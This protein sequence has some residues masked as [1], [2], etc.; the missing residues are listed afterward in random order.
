MNRTIK[1]NKYKT[2][3]MALFDIQIGGDQSI[4]RI[5][6]D[7]ELSFVT[8]LDSGWNGDSYI[9]KNNKDRPLI[10]KL[11]RMD[12]Y[13]KNNKFESEYHRQVDFDEHVA[14]K[15]PDKF[16]VLENHGIIENCVFSHSKTNDVI[17]KADDKRKA[18]FIRKNAQPNCYYL[19]YKP[20]LDGTFKSIKDQIKNDEI[21]LSDFLIQMIKSMNVYRKLGFI[22]TDVNISNIMFKRFGKKYQ[23]YW[24]DYGNITNN[25]YPD[26]QLDIERKESVPFYKTDM[27]SDLLSLI[28]RFCIT[29]NIIDHKTSGIQKKEFI[30]GIYNNEKEKYDKVIEYLP[31]FDN[32]EQ[33]KINNNI[34][35]L[36]FRILYPKEY[37]KYYSIEYDNKEQ[38]V[39]DKILQCI[40]HSNDKTYDDL[41]DNLGG[42][43][44]FSKNEEKLLNDNMEKMSKKIV[45]ISD[46]IQL[47]N[48][49]NNKSQKTYTTKDFTTSDGVLNILNL[50]SKKDLILINHGEHL[51]IL[52]IKRPNTNQKDIESFIDDKKLELHYSIIDNRK[53]I[54]NTHDEVYCMHSIGKVFTGFL[55]MMLLDENIITSNDVKIP[56]QLDNDVE[57]KLPKTI[58]D[59]L[60]ETTM[61]D[62]MTHISGL[63]NYLGNYKDT[64]RKN[65]DENPIEPEDFIK[66]IHPDVKEK[67]KYNY[68]NTGLLLCGLSIKHL[69]NKRMK[70]NKTYNEILNEYIIIPAKLQTF[71]I[72]RPNNGIFNK[73]GVDMAEFFHGSPA[74]GYWIS[75]DDLAKFGV[76]MIE[77]I[78][79][80]QKIKIY[81]KKFGGEFYSKNIISHSGAIPGSNHWFT[82][83]LKHNVSIAI[84]DNNGRHSIQ[85]KYAIDYFS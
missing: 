17:T 3:N 75:P 11:E 31:K 4:D 5:L 34:F 53:I 77:Q 35:T 12:K 9:V 63:T 20:V 44:P 22:H 57:N 51:N 85:L 36:V 66:Y 84:M 65:N 16:M 33:N 56:L 72:T 76:F 1:S 38:L 6:K 25:K 40:K 67:G 59:R 50:L 80:K 46:K 43:N 71:S 58:Q 48:L 19:L 49:I 81:L 79:E 13:D 15:Y 41:I 28:I 39:K 73:N 83:Y 23:W 62:V 18:R 7:L 68:S 78:K 55:I 52:K 10:L 47:I 74:G 32:E 45:K 82:V 29:S 30:A 54:N 70:E 21:L 42:S 60:E 26:S 2:N 69:Y 24:I 8:I 14:K 27:S 37:T 61:L 64:L